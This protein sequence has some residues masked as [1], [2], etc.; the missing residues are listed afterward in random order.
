MHGD[1]YG[2]GKIATANKIKKGLDTTLKQY[3]V[4]MSDPILNSLT[5]PL[6]VYGSMVSYR[7]NSKVILRHHASKLYGL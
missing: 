3:T 1:S 6:D 5:A 2:I 4:T 7:V